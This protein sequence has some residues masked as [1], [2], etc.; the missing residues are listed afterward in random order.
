VEN[1]YISTLEKDL[2]VENVKESDIQVESS[3]ISEGIDLLDTKEFSD[4]IS[5]NGNW[6]SEAFV[7]NPI[8]ASMVDAVFQINAN[9]DIVF[10]TERL[11]PIQI[12]IVIVGKPFS[13]KKTVAKRL[14][15]ELKLQIID[16]NELISESLVYNQVPSQDSDTEIENSKTII[17]EKIKTCLNAGKEIG[18]TILVSLV[19]IKIFELNNNPENNGWILL[20]FPRTLNQAKLLEKELSGFEEPKISI[21]GNLKKNPKEPETKSSRRKSLIAP[22]SK[23]NEKNKSFRSIMDLVIFLDVLDDVAIRR[24]LGRLQDINNGENYHSKN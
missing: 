15:D 8:L 23:E 4:Y 20:D 22:A 11:N 1:Y 24:G 14:A 16:L 3:T 17:S 7:K 10:N 9:P 21:P 18:E 6:K 12:K 5:G 19:S 2:V 13:G